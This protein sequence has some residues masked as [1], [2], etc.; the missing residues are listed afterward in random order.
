[1]PKIM[2][3]V[4]SVREGR[5][6]LPIAEWV[7]DVTLADGRFEV[8]FADL[9]E[10]ALPMMDE[11][12]HPTQQQYTKPHTIEWSKRVAAAD[13]F[14]FVFPEYNNSYAPPIKNAIDSWPK[15]GAASR[16]VL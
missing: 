16:S 11:P 14:L 9:K 2:I 15:S 5:T 6:A 7:R 4:G 10:I 8:D 12:N 3:I 13:A 1:M